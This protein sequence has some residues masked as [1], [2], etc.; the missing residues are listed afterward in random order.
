MDHSINKTLVCRPLQNTSLVRT[1]LNFTRLDIWIDQSR[2]TIHSL[3]MPLSE[4]ASSHEIR[5][6]NH[7]PDISVGSK[8]RAGL[9]KMVFW[10]IHIKLKHPK[11]SFATLHISESGH[12]ERPQSRHSNN[13]QLRTQKVVASSISSTSIHQQCRQQQSPTAPTTSQYQHRKTP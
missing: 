8:C 7:L 11:Q 12:S 6:H 1:H 5:L 4:Q 9:M 13:G 2:L 3:S 10:T